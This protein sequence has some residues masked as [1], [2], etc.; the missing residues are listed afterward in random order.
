MGVQKTHDEYVKE[1]AIKNPN[2]MVIGQYNGTNTAIE[3]YCVK[4][5][6]YFHTSPHNALYGKGCKE[7]RKE[8]KRIGRCKSHDRYVEE[9]RIK[10]PYV[11]VVGKYVNSKTKI[12]HHCLIH[13]IFWETIPNRALQGVGC[14]QC[15]IE[16]FRQSRCKTHDQYVDEV[17]AIDPSIIVIGKYIDAQTPIQHYCKKHNVLWFPY[18]DNILHGMGCKEC[19]NER[20]REK[21]I[22]SHNEYMKDLRLVNP[23]VEVI[24]EY[25]GSNTSILHRC[26]ID[27][28][29]WLAKPSN[30]LSGKGCPQCNESSGER[31]VRQWLEKY[32]I[33]YKYQKTFDDCKDIKVLP[34]DFYLPQYNTC[35]EYDGEQ[36]F[37][38]VKFDGKDENAAEKQF[39]ITK[40]HDEIKNQYCASNN[41]CLI[42]IPY[43][44]NVE[45][46][47]EKFLFI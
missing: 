12:L 37:Q 47:L 21:N 42:R 34:F 2:I 41:I 16:K 4:H 35:V 31:Q 39:K 6:A 40:K 26:K 17:T 19:G 23:D 32:N 18:P 13:D 38:P 8:K 43:Y 7:C 1:M 30:I 9:L 28:Y 46:E 15:K 20:I 25:R 24:G 27:G 33:E 14:E 10:N 29:E 36:H 44:N 45:K 3:H 5:N 11:E 22:K